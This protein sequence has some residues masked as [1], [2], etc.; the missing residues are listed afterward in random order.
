MRNKTFIIIAAGL[1]VSCT[2]K[3]EEQ[4]NT[5]EVVSDVVT[6]TVA[7]IKNSGIETGIPQERIM[8]S[9]L[10]VNGLVDVPPQNI[11]S[12]SFPI[13]GYLKSTALLPGMHVGK[14][15]VIAWMEDQALVQL[16]QDYLVTAAKLEFL[17]LEY[18]RQKLLNENNVNAD[19]VYQQAKAEY[20]SQKILLKGYSEK[21][22]LVHINPETLTE[23]TVS[24]TV[25]VYSPINGFVSKV[26]VNIGRYVNPSDVLFELINPA[27]MHAALTVF[28]KDIPKIKPKQQVLVSFVDEPKV[29]YPCEVLLVTKNVSEDRTALVHCHFVNQPKKLLPGMFLNA[30][31]NVEGAMVTAVPEEAVVRYGS[32]EYVVEAKGNNN[33]GLIAVTTGVKSEGWVEIT[34]AGKEFLTKN[35]VLK[36]PYPVLSALK[37][38]TEE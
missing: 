16:Q 5:E 11:V 28:E 18:E 23:S 15:Q 7:Q 32:S 38:T 33:F 34:D 6:L 29:E 8:N 13:G 12:V 14:G 10:K 30:K 4:K 24:R 37:N 26:N 35:L 36:N 17:R 31:I 25:P 27:D 21:L 9:E 19:K 20:L 22:R 1:L 2:S 3:K